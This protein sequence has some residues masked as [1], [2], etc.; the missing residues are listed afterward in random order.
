MNIWDK[1]IMPFILSV[2]AFFAPTYEFIL[3]IGLL[4]AAD[5]LTAIIAAHK[6]GE[7]IKSAKLA[8]TVG[9]FLVYGTALIVSHVVC[10]K[11]ISS[12]PGLQIMA[13]FIT[14]VE[15]KSIDENIKKFTGFS[16]FGTILEK[17]KPKKQSND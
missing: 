11:F 6:A 15:V 9:K 14:F 10:N 5:L 1:Y 13:G 16:L 3:L 2:G 17:L 12:F 4:I 7:P 8:R